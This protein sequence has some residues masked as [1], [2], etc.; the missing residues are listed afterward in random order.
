MTNLDI[1]TLAQLQPNALSMLNVAAQGLKL[2]ARV[3][4]RTIKV[5]RT[6]AD[7]AST[8]DITAEHVSE[9]IQYRSFDRT[10]WV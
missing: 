3:Y 8:E 2:P 7:L 9:A 1:K 4:M 10:L 6:I 5:A